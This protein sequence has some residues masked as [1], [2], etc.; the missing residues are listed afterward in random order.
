[1]VVS[2]CV[3]IF[4]CFLACVC[5]NYFNYR[6]WHGGRVPFSYLIFRPGIV[7][8]SANFARPHGTVD[9]VQFLTVPG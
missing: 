8:R 9:L 5:R 3:L 7:R 2:L 1:M 4:V 6:A